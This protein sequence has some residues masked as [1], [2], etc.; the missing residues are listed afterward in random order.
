MT[1]RDQLVAF[2][3]A[4]DVPGIPKEYDAGI[5]RRLGLLSTFYHFAF[6]AGS[7]GALEQKR[8]KSRR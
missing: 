4:R 7:D 3:G 6:E 1:G 5:N 8:Q 2:M